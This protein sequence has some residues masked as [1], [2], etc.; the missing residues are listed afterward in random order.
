VWEDN[1]GG[2]QKPGTLKKTGTGKK[3]KRGNDSRRAVAAQ[4]KAPAVSSKKNIKKDPYDYRPTSSYVEFSQN[5]PIDR[6]GKQ[7]GMSSTWKAQGM[8]TAS[9]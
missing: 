8:A 7:M 3:V 4:Q 2:R 9:G 1:R 5:G 6:V